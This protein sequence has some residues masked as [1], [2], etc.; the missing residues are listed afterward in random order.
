MFPSEFS[1]R[2]APMP[3]PQTIK[4]VMLL[5]RESFSAAEMK[6]VP[7]TFEVRVMAIAEGHAMV[8]RKGAMPFIVRERELSEL[9]AE[10]VTPGRE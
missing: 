10:S 6:M 2:T 1:E 3:N 5:T 9:P 4:K 8:R 7:E